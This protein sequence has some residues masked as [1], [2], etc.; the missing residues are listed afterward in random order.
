MM[1]PVLSSL[2]IVAYKASFSDA[3]VEYSLPDDQHR[4][5]GLSFAE[6]EEEDDSEKGVWV[7]Y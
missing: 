1:V 3:S 7:C 2:I 4:L 6:G 5:Q